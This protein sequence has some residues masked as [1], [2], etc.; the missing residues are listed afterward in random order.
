[1]RKFFVLIILCSALSVASSFVL[2]DSST[3]K[4]NPN[5]N[6]DDVA[7]LAKNVEHLAAEHGARVIIVGRIGR[8]AEDLPVGI[9][10][11][12]I[13]IGVYSMIETKDGERIPGY[14]MYNLYQDSTNKNTSYLA[15]D[16]PFDFFSS[17]QDLKAGV[18]I[19]NIKLQNKILE[20]IQSGTYK[21]LHIPRYSAIASPFTQ[22]YQNCTEYVLDIINSSIYETADMGE[23]KQYA[24]SYFEPQRVNISGLKLVVGSI[25]TQGVTTTDHKNGV[26]TATFT[27]IR[28]YLDKYGLLQAQ[29]EVTI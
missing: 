18:I 13:G 26:S 28:N 5:L 12:H 24:K 11:T 1:M 15:T 16:F 29:Y 9:N 10:Y 21:K 19:P 27:T 2:A 4:V 22:R 17:V 14:A 23:L 7:Q 6:A 8:K 20:V 25:F 3:A